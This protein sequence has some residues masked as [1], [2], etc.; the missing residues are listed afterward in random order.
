MITSFNSQ[1][2]KTLRT[3][4]E[5]ALKQLELESGVRFTVGNMRYDNEE[6]KITFTARL[7]SMPKMTKVEEAKNNFGSICYAYGMKPEHLGSRFDFQNKT[8][9]ITGINSR[10][11]K[12]PI[13]IT[14]VVTRKDYVMNQRTV[15]QLL[16]ISS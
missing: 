12:N 4:I 1:T 15:C 14:D 11:T 3:Q 13:V 9:E 16:G 2:C 7:G 10:A 6:V 5:N 8:F